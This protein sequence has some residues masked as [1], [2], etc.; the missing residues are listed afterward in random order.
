MNEKL[1][2]TFNHMPFHF[3][4]CL[5]SVFYMTHSIKKLKDYS[6]S[7]KCIIYKTISKT[8]VT[9]FSRKTCVNFTTCMQDMC[10]ILHCSK[11]RFMWFMLVG[12]IS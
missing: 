12:V 3:F 2:Q 5:L 11:T 1:N 6:D 4:I 8:L 9:T 7:I 10:Y